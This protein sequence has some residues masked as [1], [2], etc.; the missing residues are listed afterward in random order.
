MASGGWRVHPLDEMDPAGASA[1][2]STTGY[3]GVNMPRMSNAGSKNRSENPSSLEQAYWS[4]MRKRM[5]LSRL[6][7]ENEA[8]SEDR[9][10]EEVKLSVLLVLLLMKLS[11]FSTKP[12]TESED[13]KYKK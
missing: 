12:D 11:Y 4:G 9:K 6:S 3:G 7:T 1:A 13:T 8:E 5:G 2:V 10:R